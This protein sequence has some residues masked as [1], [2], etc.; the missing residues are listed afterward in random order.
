MLRTDRDREVLE[1][2]AF[3]VRMLSLDQVARAWWGRGENARRLARRRLRRLVDAGL[4]ERHEVLA[5]PLLELTGPLIS[6]APGDPD[7]DVGAV[8]YRLQ[9]RWSKPPR[10]TT[11]FVASGRAVRELGGRGG[12]LPTLGQETH[13][14]HTS[15]L[16]LR[17]RELS[18]EEA[19]RWV[20]EEA[21]KPHRERGEK[22]P[23][24]VLVDEHGE[25]ELAIEFAGSYSANRVA[26]FH[27]DCLERELPYELW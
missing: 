22:L 23:D 6:W 5:R 16:F 25:I 26:E 1:A 15:E 24:A 9:S 27:N 13:D 4:L 21:L 14:L 8:S 18:P 11:V 20:G 17:R 10:R 2:V 3:K 7:P 19:H 12:K